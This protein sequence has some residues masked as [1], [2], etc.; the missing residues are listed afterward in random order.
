MAL[1]WVVFRK[2]HTLSMMNAMSGNSLFIPCSSE[3]GGT[4]ESIFRK[5]VRGRKRKHVVLLISFWYIPDNSVF[6]IKS[7]QSLLMA[8]SGETPQAYRTFALKILAVTI[9]FSNN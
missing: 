6:D 5:F 7:R 9:D 4:E 1:I 3:N 8:S 2:L